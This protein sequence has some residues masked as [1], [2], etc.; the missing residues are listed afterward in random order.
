MIA[1]LVWVLSIGDRRAPVLVLAGVPLAFLVSTILV[2]NGD[3]YTT[4]T[5]FEVFSYPIFQDWLGAGLYLGDDG[6]KSQYGMY[7]VF[8]RPIWALWG[9]P[10]PTAIGAT[11]GVLLFC[12]EFALIAFMTR[13]TRRPVLGA[14]FALASILTSL[15]LY[16]F[17]PGDAYFEFFPTRLVFPGLAF[18]LLNWSFSRKRPFL[19][20]FLLAPGL[21]WNFESGI[22]ALAAYASF[23]MAVAFTPSWRSSLSLA[24]RH[25]AMICVATA[26]SVLVLEVDYL[27]RFRAPFN[28]LGLVNSI[29]AFSAGA[30]AEPMPPFGA[31]GL[32]CAI[33][34]LSAFV[35]FR[36]IWRGP[37]GAERYRAAALLSMAVAGIL[38]LR[39]YQGRSLPLP[40]TFVSG[41][42]VCCL[43]LLI[44]RA[45][46][47]LKPGKVVAVSISALTAAAFVGSFAIW[48]IGDP[49]PNRR[50][51]SL[52]K[53]DNTSSLVGFASQ[54]VG[55]FEAI[56]TSA[57]D[58][59]LVIAPYG[60]QVNMHLGHVGPIKAAGLC[61]I[62]FQSEMDSAL[63]AVRDPRTKMVVLDASDPACAIAAVSDVPMNKALLEGY[64]EQHLRSPCGELP[65]AGRRIFL[66]KGVRWARQGGEAPA[67]DM[68]RGRPASQIS[69]FGNAEASLAV[70]GNNC[71]DYSRG[72]VAHTGLAPSPW[73]E[74]DLGESKAIK[75]IQV[76]NRSDCCG[77]RLHNFW[78]FVS[79][80]PFGGADTP[81]AS[82]ARPDVWSTRVDE[83]PAPDKTVV[84]H[85]R[86]R[87]V[88][89]QLDDKGWLALAEVKVFGN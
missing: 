13:Y 80:R 27:L 66:R 10:S 21:L 15:L 73:W 6:Q 35:A 8:L 55:Q 79:D 81:A 85:A 31:W 86:G 54:T 47:R 34:L 23:T 68:A 56:R 4:T 63:S 1:V 74:V 36:S 72:S 70:D 16:P 87:F 60:S 69:T 43:G 48:M 88:R 2:R 83:M 76:W 9:G 58:R 39:Y 11:M 38:W 45:A 29:L 26:V 82:R 46:E 14:V 75:A 64:D 5:H 71:G 25:I 51:D 28:L 62:W 57:D 17:W 37:T 41:P 67:A 18:V 59:L 20:Y 89:V 22:V 32:H 53:K 3:G 40:L 24:L 42:A 61:Q 77:D 52:F 7:P 84:V 30:G 50:I 19:S 78:V 65:P 33:Y 44:D 49:V 12:S